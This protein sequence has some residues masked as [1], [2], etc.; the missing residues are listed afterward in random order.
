MYLD[1]SVNHQPG[2]TLEDTNLMSLHTINRTSLSDERSGIT[3]SVTEVTPILH[4]SCTGPAATDPSVSFWHA[5]GDLL[6]A[7][8]FYRR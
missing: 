7:A 4:P 1:Y 2:L 6:F 8:A 5:I 3:R